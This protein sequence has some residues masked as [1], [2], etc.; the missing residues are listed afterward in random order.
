MKFVDEISLMVKAGNGGSGA[1]SFYHNYRNPKGGP[2]GGNG[3][4]GG[5]VYFQGDEQLN[6]FFSLSSR[7]KWVAG[8]GANGQRQLKT[9]KNGENVH[10]KV[11]L[12]T[13]IKST[14]TLPQLENKELVLGEILFPQQKLLIARGGKGGWGNAAFASSVNRS[15]YY[16]QKGI[17][18]EELQLKLELKILADVGLLGL[19]SAGKSTLINS[20][21]NAKVKTAA[22]PFTTL[23]PQLGVLTHEDQKIVIADLPGIIEGAVHGKGLGLKFLKHIM[24]CSL[25]IYILDANQDHPEKDLEVL[26]KE[27]QESGIIE[28]Q[29][30]QK[31]IIWN[32]VD[33]LSFEREKRLRQEIIPNLNKETNLTLKHFFISA[34]RKTN[35]DTL[36]KEIG[37][38]VQENKQISSPAPFHKVYD[39]TVPLDWQIIPLKSHYWKLTGSFI[40][41]LSQKYPVEKLVQKLKKTNLSEY[42]QQK[43]VKNNDIIIINN[44]EFFWRYE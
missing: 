14:K 3:G 18:G 12:G 8:S 19:P 13:I 30:K 41:N 34:L 24:R 31:I 10:I 35:L 28:P 33:L 7:K 23:H 22:F 9:G 32:K 20:L 25:I 4:S 36:V 40:E 1:V 16:A 38:T 43:K 26:G 2:D 21:T 42:L 27:L 11:P 37:L 6:S 44:Q 5:S 29:N 17:S 15:P 39:F